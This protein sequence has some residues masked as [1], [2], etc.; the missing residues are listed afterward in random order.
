MKLAEIFMEESMKTTK[1]TE[2]RQGP[3]AAESK[4]GIKTLPSCAFVV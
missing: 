1:T 4:E 3:R 2:G